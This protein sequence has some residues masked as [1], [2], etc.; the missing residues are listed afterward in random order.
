MEKDTV[1]NNNT[2]VLPTDPNPSPSERVKRETVVQIDS[3][4]DDE[5]ELYYVG[6][7]KGPTKIATGKMAEYVKRFLEL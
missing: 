1:M 7:K 2:G 4:D 3:S 5:N 6:K